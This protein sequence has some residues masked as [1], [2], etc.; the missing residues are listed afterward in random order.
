MNE[1][2]NTVSGDNSDADIELGHEKNFH[3]GL[4]KHDN[5][6]LYIPIALTLSEISA[7]PMIVD[8]DAVD[9]FHK[10]LQPCGRSHGCAQDAA[11]RA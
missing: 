11:T 6:S 2:L 4:N 8:E 3:N 10:N 1:T 9:H 7:I 5:E